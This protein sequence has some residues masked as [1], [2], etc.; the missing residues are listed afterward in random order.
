MYATFIELSSFEKNRAQYLNDEQYRNFQQMLLENP[1]KGDLIPETGGLRK[2]RFKDERRGKGTRDGIRVIYY[3][4]SGNGKFILFTLYDKD[5]AD[6]MTKQERN[7]LSNAL[8]V[9]KKG[10]KND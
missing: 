2:V 9:I 4:T 6:D 3:W 8:N 5:Q 10:L 7:A 1:E